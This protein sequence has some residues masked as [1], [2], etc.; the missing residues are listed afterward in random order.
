MSIK[1]IWKRRVLGPDEIVHA[2]KARGSR[3]KVC[4]VSTFYYDGY[5]ARTIRMNAR[6]WFGM[7]IKLINCPVCR[8]RL[9]LK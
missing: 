9:E 3:T 8:E 2:R 6:H 7:D 4:E 1:L 5:V